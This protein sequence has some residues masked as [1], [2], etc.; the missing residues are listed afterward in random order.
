M[1]WPKTR[2]SHILTHYTRGKIVS[3]AEKLKV[4]DSTVCISNC[5]LPTISFALVLLWYCAVQ[6][7]CWSINV[8][9]Q[10]HTEGAVI[11]CLTV[12]IGGDAVYTLPI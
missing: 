10:K 9:D 7:F 12:T 6:A 3:T 2:T 4:P 8:A 1:Q 11:G 5:R